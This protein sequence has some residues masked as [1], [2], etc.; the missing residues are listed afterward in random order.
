MLP[1]CNI[2]IVVVKEENFIFLI[3]YRFI[4]RA[5]ANEKK[6]TKRN[7]YSTRQTINEYHAVNV[8]I[9]NVQ[10]RTAGICLQTVNI[11]LYNANCTAFNNGICSRG[12][13]QVKN[14]RRAH[15]TICL[16]KVLHCKLFS[17]FLLVIN[18]GRYL[19]FYC[20]CCCPRRLCTDA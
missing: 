4:S 16:H 1:N 7:E 13:L 12:N 9:I 6:S 20:C 10:T 5:L 14:A 18:H 19:I 11:L 3:N 15:V 2:T 8:Q 17:D